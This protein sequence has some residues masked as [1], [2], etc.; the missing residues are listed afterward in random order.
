MS[1]A[2]S[3]LAFFGVDEALIGDLV[4]QYSA[5]RS[6][7]WLCKQIAVALAVCVASAVRSDPNI[8]GVT[9]VVVVVALALPSVWMHFIMHYAIMLHLAWYPGAFDWLARSSPPDA[10]WQLVVF[11]H[12]W[13]WTF[14]AEW[15]ALLALLTCCL[16]GIW[17]RRARLI[18]AVFV[19]SN[20]GQ[21]LPYL[22]QSFV[23]WLHA[24]FNLVWMSNFVCY[25]LFHLVAIPAAIVLSACCAQQ[26]VS[27]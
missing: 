4:E 11:V 5:G 3:V 25:A 20:V 16:V 10:L 12:P 2:V 6:A 21:S 13:E 17:P 18:L 22:E 9:A 15:C 27:S 8:V 7:L 24:P 26:F 14:W 23:D 19:L 1:V